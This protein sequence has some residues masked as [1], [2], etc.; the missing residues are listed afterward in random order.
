MLNREDMKEMLSI[1]TD[2]GT[3]D[4]YVVCR[5]SAGVRDYIALTPQ[6]G[7]DRG[8]Q[9]FRRSDNESGIQ[10]SNIESS[11]E[12]DDVKRE[13]AKVMMNER[14][15]L[16][17]NDNFDTVVR[18]ELDDGT[19]TI[20]D[21]LGL[22]EFEGAGYIAVMPIDRPDELTVNIGL[23]GYTT[24]EDDKNE[25]SITLSPIPNYLF[26]SV[27]EYFMDMYEPAKT[28]DLLIY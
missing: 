1:T 19:E 7:N 18:I 14:T 26:P 11:M 20:C 17:K 9:L 27:Q 25:V 24:V 8:I 6:F 23:Y 5:L 21:I 4:Y 28:E 12:F 2:V 22:F 10:V 15:D 16:F 3:F 13:Y